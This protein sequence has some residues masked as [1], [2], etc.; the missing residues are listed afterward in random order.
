MDKQRL[1]F[2]AHSDVLGPMC[3]L[4]H[5]TEV[6]TTCSQSADNRIARPTEDTV[7]LNSDWHSLHMWVQRICVCV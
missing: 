3:D 7:V 5:S 4:G 1:F 2:A 6:V